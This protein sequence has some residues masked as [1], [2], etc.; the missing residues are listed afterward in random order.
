MSRAIDETHQLLNKASEFNWAAV[1]LVFIQRHFVFFC[2]IFFLSIYYYF[3]PFAK[4]GDGVR[5]KRTDALQ[6]QQ[7]QQQPRTCA[8][9]WRQSSCRPG[10]VLEELRLMLA[11]ERREQRRRGAAGG[12]GMTCEPSLHRY[13]KLPKVWVR[14]GRVD[15]RRDLTQVNELTA[16]RPLSGFCFFLV[17]FPSPRLLSL[18]HPA[19]RQGA[20]GT[21]GRK[22]RC[23][24]FFFFFFFD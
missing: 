24:F 7:E 17:S 16:A 23:F 19:R 22:S 9:R 12:K 21:G 18:L 11:A 4:S 20:A 3:F 8:H 13:N 10:L 15:A 1:V 6:P 5:G 2:F 14:Q